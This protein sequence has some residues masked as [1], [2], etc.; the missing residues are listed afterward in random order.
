MGISGGGKTYSSLLIAKGLAGTLNK[1]VVIDAEHSS[2]DLYAHLGGYSVLPM[3]PP[4]SPEK[5][6]QAIQIAEESGF[7]VIILDSISHEWEAEGGILDIHSSMPGNS[8]ANWNLVSKRHNR[9]INSIL[10]SKCHVIAT[11]RTK[12]G[13]VLTEKNGKMTPEKVGLKGIAREGTDYS[14]T[15]VL[16]I[17]QKHFCVATKDRTGIFADRPE[18]IVTENT[19][20]EIRD[21]CNISNQLS[22]KNET[23]SV[24][25]K[26]AGIVSKQFNNPFDMRNG[27]K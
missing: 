9:F 1:V 14:F 15:V 3:N 2:A 11:I 12:Q 20:K 4:Y 17:N 10:Q 13:Y 23:H 22:R 16:N 18:F 24:A 26:S 19:G 27:I 6:I 8:F 25:A 21:W 5:Y 7:D